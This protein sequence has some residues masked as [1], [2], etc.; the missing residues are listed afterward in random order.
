MEKINNGM[1]VIIILIVGFLIYHLWG[2]FGY[3]LEKP[4]S[5]IKKISIRKLFSAIKLDLSEKYMKCLLMLGF[6]L[7]ILEICILGIFAKI[8]SLCKDKIETEVQDHW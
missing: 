4:I 2:V 6:T 1:V 8:V 5:T 7:F 3:F